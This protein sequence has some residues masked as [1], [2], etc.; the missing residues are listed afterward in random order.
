MQGIIF[1]TINKVK[2]TDNFEL[3]KPLLNWNSPDEYYFIQ[4]LQRKKDAGPGIKVNGTNNNSRLVKAYYVSSLEYLDFIT[5]EIV[6]LC[7]I[8]G[9]RAGINLNKRSFEKTALQHLK[10]VTDNI[11]NKNFNKVY[12][13]YSSA[14]GKFSHDKNKKWIIDVDKED[15]YLKEDIIKIVNSLQPYNDLQPNKIICEI[16][17]KTGLHLIS[18]PF[19][20][21]EFKLNFPSIDVGKN[22]PTNLYIP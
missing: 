11:L 18:S 1:I 7:E 12:K 2:M 6:Q 17:S 14:A 8:F 3:I 16:P 21:H 22:N 4:V 13:T 9:A 10:L 19:N 15:L 5:P 20:M